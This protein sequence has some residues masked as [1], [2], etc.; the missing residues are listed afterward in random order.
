MNTYKYVQL[1]AAGIKH[2]GLFI[3][4][5]NIN[6]FENAIRSIFWICIDRKQICI[7]NRQLALQRVNQINLDNIPLST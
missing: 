4:R 3:H 7:F 5:D 6:M 2:L 1:N